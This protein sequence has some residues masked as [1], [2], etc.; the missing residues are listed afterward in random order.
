[1]PLRP[2]LQIRLYGLIRTIAFFRPEEV[3]IVGGSQPPGA[4]TACEVRSRLDG[5]ERRFK[6][7]TGPTLTL[8]LQRHYG[9]AGLEISPGATLRHGDQPSFTARRSDRHV[10]N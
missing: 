1:M 4:N 8:M 3:R 9:G 10:F 6:A 7:H 2:P 5:S